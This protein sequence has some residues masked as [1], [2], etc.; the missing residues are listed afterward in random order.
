MK[1]LAVAIL[2]LLFILIPGC[3][4]KD[5]SLSRKYGMILVELGSF[6]MGAENGYDYEKP[7]HRVRITRPFYISAYEVTFN[8]FDAYTWETNKTRTR[9]EISEREKRP[10]TGISWLDAVAYCNWLGKK[11]DLRPC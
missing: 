10:A 9:A 11:E 8:Q 5:T 4:S 3:E 2:L 7:V 6:E 1:L